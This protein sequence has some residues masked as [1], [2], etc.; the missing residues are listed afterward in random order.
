M[1][2]L[3]IEA[4]LKNEAFAKFVDEL[5]A[6]LRNELMDNI[7]KD[8]LFNIDEL[9]FSME[10]DIKKNNE[11]ILDSSK[12]SLQTELKRQLEQFINSGSG[13]V[14]FSNAAKK[15]NLRITANQALLNIGMAIVR[16]RARNG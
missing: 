14:D 4:F 6:Q 12:R 5:K 8:L 1:V 13:S 15:N 10:D 16:S 2:D 3:N 9:K 7:K 11:F